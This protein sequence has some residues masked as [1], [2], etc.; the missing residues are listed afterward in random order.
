MARL[1]VE[2]NVEL[3]LAGAARDIHVQVL[4]QLGHLCD[5]EIAAS[6][7]LNEVESA[8]ESAVRPP[9]ERGHP[10]RIA[11]IASPAARA[12]TTTGGVGATAG[13]AVGRVAT[14]SSPSASSAP[15]AKSPPLRLRNRREVDA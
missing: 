8:P 9:G 11:G 1:R 4:E 15:S 14:A 3:P 7:R 2:P 5:E 6:L 10:C 12:T 13:G